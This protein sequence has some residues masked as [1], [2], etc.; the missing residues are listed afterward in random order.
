MT[1]EL[2]THYKD[3]VRKLHPDLNQDDPDAGTDESRKPLIPSSATY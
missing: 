2:K 3:M 1:D